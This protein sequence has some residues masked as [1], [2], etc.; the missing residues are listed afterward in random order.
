[1]SNCIGVLKDS[2]PKI[3]TIAFDCLQIL[4]E[5][6]GEAFQPLINIA[7]DILLTKL[8]DSKVMIII[9]IVTNSCLNSCWFVR[10]RL[11]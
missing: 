10:E 9:I 7:F 11:R 8:C 4:I 2:N 1:M 6:N 3:V 5:N